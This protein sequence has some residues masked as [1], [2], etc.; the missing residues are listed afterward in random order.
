MDAKIAERETSFKKAADPADAKQARIE[1]AADVR[2]Q[3]RESM[4]NQ[5]RVEAG[6]AMTPAVAIDSDEDLAAVND[7]FEDGRRRLADDATATVEQKDQ[8]F[9]VDTSQAVPSAA[10]P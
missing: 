10:C 5:K 1:T 6:A 7:H 9:Q 3:Q 2:K 4:M 8:L